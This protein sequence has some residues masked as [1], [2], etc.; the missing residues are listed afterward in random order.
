MAA[1]ALPKDLQKDLQSAGSATILQD[2]AKPS[3]AK[4]AMVD[5]GQAGG[6]DALERLNEAMRELKALAV[7]PLIKRSIEALNRENFVA[8]GK[9]AIKALDKD[10]RNGVA[11][12]LLAISRERAGDFPNSIKAYEAALQL[13]PNHAD[14]AND[15]GRLAY[16]MGMHAQSEKLFRHYMEHAPHEP[17]GYNNLASAVKDQGRR[18]EAIEILRE[19]ISAMPDSAMLWNTLGTIMIEGGDLENAA[20]FIAE[21]VR[22]DPK[23]SKGRYNLSQVKLHL[24]EVESALEDCE[25]ALIKTS[26]AD[27]RE[28]MKL[29]RSSYQLALGRLTAGWDDYEAR[30]SPQFADVTHFAIDKP[31]WQPGQDIAGKTFLVVGEQGLGDEVLFANVIPDVV[32]NLGPNGRLLIAVEPRLVSL[33]QRSFPNAE[34]SAHVTRVW[35]T[36]PLR[37]V[38][39]VDVEQIDLWTPVAS[40]MRQYRPSLESFPSDTSGY[41]KADPERVE[42]WRRLLADAGEGKKVG[43]LWKSAVTS[44]HRHRYFSAFD[45]WAPVLKTPGVTFVNLQ[46][47][48]CAE[49]IE[50]A[51]RDF[52]VEIWSPPEIDLKK[53][54]DDVTALACAMDLVIGFSNATFNLG[55]SAGAPSWLISAPGAWPRLS[56]T[57]RYAWY[58]QTRVFV[59]TRYQEWTPVFDRI[60]GDLRAFAAK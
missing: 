57:D 26:T 6:R 13:L 49:E 2:A 5:M 39:G 9:W 42:H 21:A 25:A 10:E 29:A 37:L 24:G 17:Q 11:W 54:L 56:L 20:T 58:P 32:R 18:D 40:L 35:A 52:G 23:F 15:L 1:N 16:R 60:A 59:P 8:G 46:Y 48:D 19:A 22:L 41:M 55:A 50:Q 4:A 47:G 44:G 53:D 12:Y 36:R 45:Q 28:M 7:A 34:V 27:D 31:R 3:P 30:L 33:F 14:V 51:R 43:L 38:P